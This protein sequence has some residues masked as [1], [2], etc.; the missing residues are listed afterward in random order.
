MD[1]LQIDGPAGR[2]FQLC[3][4]ILLKSFLILF[5]F[6]FFSMMSRTSGSLEKEQMTFRTIYKK[7][8][9]LCNF[10]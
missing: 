1:S 7:T 4:I 10:L 9:E 3:T 5:C 6:F 2:T 8:K